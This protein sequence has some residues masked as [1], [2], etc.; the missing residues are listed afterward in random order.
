MLLSHTHK[1]IFV[2]TRK[3]AGTS[4]EVDLSKFMSDEDIVTPIIPE[5]PGHIPRN[6]QWEDRKYSS[7][8]KFYNHMPAIEIESKVGDRIYNSYFKFCVEREPIDK[9]VS[10]YSMKRNSPTHNAKTRNLSWEK[11]VMAGDFP[12][13]TDKYTDQKGNLIVDRIIRFEN[14]ENEISDLSKKLNI[15][16]ETITTRAK[17]G[18]RTEV[19]VTPEQKERIYSAFES[20]NRFTGY[21]I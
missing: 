1:F 13:D 20:S 17:S 5:E 6:F 14:L 19:D 9:C 10:H 7:K 12:I 18:F 2:K 11:Y 3:T 21:E 15:G 8:N 4:I 16:L